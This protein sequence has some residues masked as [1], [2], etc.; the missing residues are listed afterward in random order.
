MRSTAYG[1]G[2]DVYAVL[3]TVEADFF[4]GLIGGLLRLFH[5]V[6]ET[7]DAEDAPAVADGVAV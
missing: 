7:D 6:A 2:G 5:G 3:H 4:H 1:F